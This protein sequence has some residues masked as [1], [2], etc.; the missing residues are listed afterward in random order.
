MEAIVLT[1]SKE[2]SPRYL[3]HQHVDIEV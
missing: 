2:Q 1:L 3:H